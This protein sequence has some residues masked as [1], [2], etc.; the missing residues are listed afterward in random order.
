MDRG[1]RGGLAGPVGADR[2]GRG[3]VAD[4]VHERVADGGG[5]VEP[6]HAAGLAQPQR[7]E[8][9]D[10]GAEP[11]AVEGVGVARVLG[12]EGLEE[13]GAEDVVGG[14]DAVHGEGFG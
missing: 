5:A 3:A 2:A 13:E 1:P 11:E 8:V 9:A 14:G 4:Q 12:L 7:G 6:D 10:R